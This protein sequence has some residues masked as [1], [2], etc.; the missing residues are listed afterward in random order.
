[1]IFLVRM[2]LTILCGLASTSGAGIF[3]PP[4]E[5]LFFCSVNYFESHCCHQCISFVGQMG[6]S[7]EHN[8]NMRKIRGIVVAKSNN[9]YCVVDTLIS[10]LYQASCQ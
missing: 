3:S 2:P 1:M 8:S 7:V 6:L 4:V 5:I 10:S 9:I